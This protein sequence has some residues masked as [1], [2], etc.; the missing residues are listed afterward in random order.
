MRG[1]NEEHRLLRRVVIEFPH[2][3]FT[4]SGRERTAPLPPGEG[5]VKHIEKTCSN[6]FFDQRPWLLFQQFLKKKGLEPESVHEEQGYLVSIP[7]DTDDDLMESIEAYYDE[8]LDM[9]EELFLEQQDDDQ[10]HAA[11][12]SVSLSDG[13]SVDALVNPKLLNRMLE[14]VSTDELGQFVSAIVD[15]VENPDN[16]PFCRRHRDEAE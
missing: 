9:N 10:V 6:I 13:R 16:R 5:K 2:P 7:D 8:M 1:V 14:V 3:A 4:L 11:G 15:A 12:V